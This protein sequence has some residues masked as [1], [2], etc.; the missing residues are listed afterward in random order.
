M[1]K[2]NELNIEIKKLNDSREKILEIFRKI[3]ISY[4]NIQKIKREN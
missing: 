2:I 3:E 1:D 4:S